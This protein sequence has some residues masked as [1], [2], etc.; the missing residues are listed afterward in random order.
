MRLLAVLER[1]GLLERSADTDRYRIGLRAFELG[2]VYI[3][4]LPMESVRNHS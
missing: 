2:S 3:Q 1:R 4:S